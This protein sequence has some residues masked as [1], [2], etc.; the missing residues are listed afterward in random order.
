M[1]IVAWLHR[2][3]ARE[4][5]G[6]R[7]GKGDSIVD[8]VDYV[9]VNGNLMLNHWHKK[10]WTYKNITILQN[11]I[12]KIKDYYNSI[13]SIINKM[14]ATNKDVDLNNN[15]IPMYLVL[16]IAKKFKDEKVE[17]LPPY[18]NVDELISEF[19]ISEKID[20]KIKLIYWKLARKILEDM[21]SI[22]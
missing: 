19:T 11:K 3:L 2:E 16:A 10:G 6:S 15:W 17:I 8:N 18:I 21:K 5:I 22:K 7:H 20:R 13:D 1:C 4:E 9:R 14:I 12:K